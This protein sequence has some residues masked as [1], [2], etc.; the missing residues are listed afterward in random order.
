[1]AGSVLFCVLFVELLFPD[2]SELYT[3]HI[4]MTVIENEIH[5]EHVNYVKTR[6]IVC[7][8]DLGVLE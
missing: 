3:K 2:M 4:W 1:V 8:Q 7:V 5:G 6:I